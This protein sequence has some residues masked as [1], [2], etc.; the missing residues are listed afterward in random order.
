MKNMNK[1][2][3]IANS[4][5]KEARDFRLREVSILGLILVWSMVIFLMALHVPKT[6]YGGQQAQDK[7]KRQE[8]QTDNHNQFHGKFLNL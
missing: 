5:I 7:Q 4:I 1:G 8:V 3:I 6:D 2:S